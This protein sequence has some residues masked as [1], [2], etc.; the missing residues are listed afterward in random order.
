MRRRRAPSED[1]RRWWN[2]EMVKERR[3]QGLPTENL[4]WDTA[5]YLYDQ[6]MSPLAAAERIK[7][8]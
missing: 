8:K 2:E 6:G 7:V 4:D 5:M 1:R 3:R